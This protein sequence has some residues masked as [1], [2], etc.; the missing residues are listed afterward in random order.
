[1]QL[2]LEQIHELA[3]DSSSVAAG[4]KLMALKNWPEL[5]RSETALWGKCQGSKVYQVRVDRVN[6]GYN[7]NCP[8]RK[9][10]CKHVL[11]LLMLAASSPDALVTTDAPEWVEDWLSK[12]QAREAKQ[13]ARADEPE[14]PVDEKAQQKRAAR[15]EARVNDGVARLDLW[16]NDLVRGGLAGVEAKS[17]SFWDEQARRLVDAQA[18][19]LASRVSRLSEIPG[20]SREWPAYFLSEAGRLKLLMHAWRR[21][22]ELDPKLQSDIRQI[23]GWN[24]SQEELLSSGEALPDT[25]CLYGQWIDDDGR[26][27]TQRTW[28][29]GRESGRTALLLQFA[30]G[31]QPFSEP[32][33]PGTQ[34]GGTLAFYPGAAKQRARFAKTNGD[35]AALNERLPGHRSI[36]EF[37]AAVSDSLARQPWLSAHG[38]VLHDVTLVPDEETWHVR[39]CDGCG[40]PLLGRSHWKP[41][42]MTGGHP[43]DLT[44]EWDGHRL[45]PLGLVVG[46]EFR[47]L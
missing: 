31:G 11:G 27:K 20:S 34:Q 2:T 23:I 7:C 24:I 41:L 28:A 14:K 30:A 47:T 40:L 8:S 3:P 18:P 5:G 39:D 46:G 16:L 9:F 37:L 43:F 45:R 44:G 12:R 21:I 38:C 6:L 42:A 33:L 17:H 32:V 15:R 19:G 22:D 4:K 29:V 25:W 36:G 26:L 1:M 35:L 10:P 13:A